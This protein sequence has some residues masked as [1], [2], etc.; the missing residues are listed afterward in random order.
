MIKVYLEQE[1]NWWAE[2]IATF[3]NEEA[4]N[5]VFD[6]LEE[7]AAKAGCIITDS[8]LDQEGGQ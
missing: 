6:A 4:Y 8:V 7:W 1:G 2:E 5:A 3:E